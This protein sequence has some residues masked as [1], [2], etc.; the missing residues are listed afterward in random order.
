MVEETEIRKYL[1]RSEDELLIELGTAV[2]LFEAPPPDELAKTEAR[3][4]LRRQNDRI[5]GAI[6]TPVVEEALGGDQ[7]E[8]VSAVA[9]AID[10]IGWNGAALIAVLVVRSGIKQMCG[11]A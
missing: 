1:A 7:F 6:C 10:E 4:W 9:T 11:W 3:N 5:K 2:S 8:L